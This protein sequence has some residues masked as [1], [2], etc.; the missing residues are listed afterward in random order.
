MDELVAG[1]RPRLEKAVAN[2]APAASLVDLRPLTGGSSSLTFVAT[3]IGAD[4]DQVVVKMAPQGLPPVRNRDVLR[5][6]RLMRAL[7]PLPQ[8][9]ITRSLFEVEAE[10]LEA[11]PFFVM[12][13]VPGECLEPRSE[14]RRVGK[15]CVSTCRSRWSPDH[16]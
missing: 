10:S 3:L 14:E 2:W 4:H 6:A 9:L 15:E 16:Y 5:Q 12:D 13:M 1:L 7:E 8:V 11:P